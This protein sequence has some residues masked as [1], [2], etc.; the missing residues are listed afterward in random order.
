MGAKNRLNVRYSQ[1]EGGEPNP[2]SGSRSPFTGYGSGQAK[3]DNVALW[4]KNQPFPGA[5]FYSLAAELNSQI[6]SKLNNTFRATYTTR[7]TRV[8]PTA[9]FFPFVDI[10][11]GMTAATS[12]SVGT[13]YI[14]FGYEP[15]TFGNLRESEDVFICRQPE[16]DQREKITG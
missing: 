7:T 15:F 10:L 3:I 2:V 13:P 4:F 6:G 12:S 11:D 14:A 8:L 9:G 5:N 16:L 1:V